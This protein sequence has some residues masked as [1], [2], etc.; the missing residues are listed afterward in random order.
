MLP[1][2]QC[3]T[4]L[5]PLK[6]DCVTFCGQVVGFCAWLVTFSVF[7]KTDAVCN[8]RSCSVDSVHVLSS[9]VNFPYIVIEGETSP[10]ARAWLPQT[11]TS[12]NVGFPCSVSRDK[13]QTFPKAG[14][15]RA[16]LTDVSS[17]CVFNTHLRNEFKRSM[18]VPIGR[19]AGFCLHPPLHPERD[20]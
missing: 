5:L 11:Q 8:S 15:L 4:E 18:H 13:S 9:Q 17:M 7:L 14:S 2:S 1:T 12:K 16:M 20:S 19:A 6:T 3:L 10:R